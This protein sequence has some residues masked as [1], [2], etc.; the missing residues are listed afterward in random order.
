M[1][2]ASLSRARI[3][4]DVASVPEPCWAV[5]DGG[6]TLQALLDVLLAAEAMAR[7]RPNARVLLRVEPDG[8]TI[9]LHVMTEGGGSAAQESAGAAAPATPL[10]IGAQL[11]AAAR[12][13]RS[14]GGGLS[15]ATAGE[16]QTLTLRIPAYRP[17]T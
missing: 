3:A 15:L 11:W 12:L 9:A 2:R 10:T 16:A 14:Q 6:R 17:R 8:D 7:H 1:R 5:A 4:I 13:A